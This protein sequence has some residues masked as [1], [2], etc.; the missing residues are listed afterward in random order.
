MQ[1][2]LEQVSK[3][4]GRRLHDEAEKIYFYLKVLMLMDGSKSWETGGV[5]REENVGVSIQTWRC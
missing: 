5:N 3:V 4:A 2:S 1:L